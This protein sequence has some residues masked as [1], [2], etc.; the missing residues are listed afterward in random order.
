[1]NMKPNRE[2]YMLPIAQLTRSPLNVRKNAGGAGLEELAASIDAQGLL[3]NLTVVETY[4]KGRGKKV[5]K[6]AVVAGAR[7]LAALQL[8]IERGQLKPTHEVPC[9]LVEQDEAVELSLAEN[10]ARTD[11]H[12]ADRFEAFKALVDAGKPVDD[13]AARFGCASTTVTKLLKLANV[14]PSFIALYRADGITLGSLQALAL[15]DDHARQKAV[16][17]GLPSH[18]RHEHAIRRMLTDDKLPST[19]RLAKFIGLKAYEKAGGAVVRDLFGDHCYLADV[20]LVHQLVAA[21]LETAQA[22]VRKEGWAWCQAFDETPSRDSLAKFG[23]VRPRLRPATPDE[24]AK[25]DALRTEAETLDAEYQ[26]LDVSSD[27]GGERGDQIDERQQAIEEELAEIDATREE[28]DPAQQAVAGC[29]IYIDDYSGKLK[30]ERNLLKPE[31]ARRL[32]HDAAADA[33]GSTTAPP[34]DAGGDPVSMQARLAAHRTC[35]LQVELARRPATALVAIVHALAST[36][37]YQRGYAGAI[38]VHGTRPSLTGQGGAPD[39]AG[40]A[41]DLAMQAMAGHWTALLPPDDDHGR[42]F[43]HL[44]TMPTETLLE[45]LAYL[46]A[47]YVRGG[48]NDDSGLLGATVALDMHAWWTPTAAAYF[49]ALQKSRILDCIAEITGAPPSPDVAKMKKAA[50]AAHAE[51]LVEAGG[52]TWLPPTLRMEPQPC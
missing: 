39:I 50:L 37:F 14:A 29:V 51:S 48:I 52:W 43:A 40:S 27:D 22:K 7:R 1:M 19:D 45:L 34:I 2:L 4:I 10:S 9:L 8:L 38:N 47:T 28:V 32:Q 15:T 31:D 16:W 3:Q 41:P 18:H 23:R 24:Q 35:A 46:S 44:Q 6:Y 26:A 49:G 5:V 21:K 11:M 33:G 42:L 25:I 36:V 30:T 17:N 12:P 13:I 20:D